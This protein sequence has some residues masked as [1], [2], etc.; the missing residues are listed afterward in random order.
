[1]ADARAIER[2]QA[3]LRDERESLTLYQ[4]LASAERDPHLATIYS[5]MAAVEG[6]HAAV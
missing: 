4:I 2:Y 5:K 6:H 3:N 1:M